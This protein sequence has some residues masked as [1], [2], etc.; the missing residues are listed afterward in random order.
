MK[1]NTRILDDNDIQQKIKRISYE[2][3]E[4]NYDEK[5]LIFI[6]ITDNGLNFAKRITEYLQSISKI[7]ITLAKIHLEKEKP[8]SGDIEMNIEGNKLNNKVVILVDD[9]ANSGKTLSYS[10]RPV[11]QFMPKKIQVAV[12]VDRKHKSFPVSP[13]YI[14][15]SLSTTMK[16]HVSVDLQKGKESVYLS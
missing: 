7:D 10:M 8:L 11:L 16:E 3:L 12:L 5:E 4:D 13:D 15:L 6:G 9:V 2:I 1:N 14:G